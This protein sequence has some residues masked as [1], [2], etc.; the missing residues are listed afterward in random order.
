MAIPTTAA[1]ALLIS[2]S[3][4]DTANTV[5]RQLLRRNQWERRLRLDHHGAVNYAIEM[6]AR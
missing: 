1:D 4:I 5:Y 6:P 2:D 3:D